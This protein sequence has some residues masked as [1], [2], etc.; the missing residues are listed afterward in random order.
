M[1]FF[2]IGGKSWYTVWA[3]KAM[4]RMLLSVSLAPIDHVDGAR[5]IIVVN[6]AVMPMYTAIEP[7]G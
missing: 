4:I 5:S 3:M 1:I 6:R 2:L 7:K